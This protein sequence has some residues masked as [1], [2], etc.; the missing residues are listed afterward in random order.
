[1]FDEEETDDLPLPC[2]TLGSKTL[3]EHQVKYLELNG[4]YDIYIV[5]HKE[6]LQ[7]VK[8]TLTE[9]ASFDERSNVYLVVVHEEDVGNANA[10]KMM[11]ELQFFQLQYANLPKA[12]RDGHMRRY[13]KKQLD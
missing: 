4:L 1:M 13:S 11:L 6:I 9:Q 12:E 10:L 3:L 5:I 8:K 2:K 7:T